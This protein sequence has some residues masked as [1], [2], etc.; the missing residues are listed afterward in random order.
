MSSDNSERTR[1]EDRY[2]PVGR[3]ALALLVR[4]LLIV[5]FVTSLLGLGV[6]Y[7]TTYDDRWYDPDA[8]ADIG[9]AVTVS[10]VDVGSHAAPVAGVTGFE[11]SSVAVERLGP[12]YVAIATSQSNGEAIEVDTT[13]TTD[14]VPGTVMTTIG[15]GMDP[16]RYKLGVSVMGVVSGMALFLHNWKPTPMGWEGRCG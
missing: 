1:L 2:V 12:E 16:E 15:P 6:H 3:A 9:I 14:D 13:L 4:V 5:L 7:A 10:I 8:T 11:D